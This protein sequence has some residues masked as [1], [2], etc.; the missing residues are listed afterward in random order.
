MSDKLSKSA[1]TEYTLSFPSGTTYT[2]YS[3]CYIN[4][5]T[6]FIQLYV[7][8]PQGLVSGGAVIISQ[9]PTPKNGTLN[10]FVTEMSPA[11]AFSNLPAYFD[12]SAL[13]ARQASPVGSTILGSIMYVMD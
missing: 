4:E 1:W 2:E 13:R 3:H 11:G 10:V 8:F 12:G 5:K 6:V 7:T 9:A